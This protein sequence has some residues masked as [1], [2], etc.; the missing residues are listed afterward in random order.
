MNWFVGSWPYF[1]QYIPWN[2]SKNLFI[3]SFQNYPEQ[4]FLRTPF[5]GGVV[6]VDLIMLFF[7]L[8]SR[9]TH[10]PA[11]APSYLQ[12]SHLRF[13]KETIK[14]VHL[15]WIVVVFQIVNIQEEL[16]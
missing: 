8:L 3:N 14:S 15:H 6:W 2:W 1:V 13:R 12:H 16:L 7:N 11:I 10:P 5:R 4:L 9:T